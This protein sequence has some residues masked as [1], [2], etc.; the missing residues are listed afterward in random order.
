MENISIAPPCLLRLLIVAVLHQK[1]SFMLNT[2]QIN[3]HRSLMIPDLSKS[4]VGQK[5]SL[6]WGNDFST[7]IR[8]K[9]M[10]SKST[11]EVGKD[12]GK[13]ETHKHPYCPFF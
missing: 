6:N 1:E 7:G 9:L 13:S 2:L 11:F 3:I 5:I 12:N 8:R 10:M 4:S